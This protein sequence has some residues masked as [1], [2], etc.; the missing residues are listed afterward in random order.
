MRGIPGYE[1][2]N[3]HACLKIAHPYNELAYIE[4]SIE[5]LH[6]CFIIHLGRTSNPSDGRRPGL[7]PVAFHLAVLAP[8]CLSR[9]QVSSTS[10]TLTF[11]STSTT[12]A[13]S[14]T[15]HLHTST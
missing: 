13:H 5:A 3:N 10:K 9:V 12:R 6:A 15:R 14:S 7:T 2:S 8:R 11:V 4:A 1:W